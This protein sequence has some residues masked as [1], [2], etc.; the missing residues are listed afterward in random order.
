MRQWVKQRIPNGIINV[1]VP[2]F[3]GTAIFF[4][5]V[6]GVMPIY[7]LGEFARTQNSIRMPKERLNA[8]R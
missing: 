2:E 6:C 4:L 7:A 8:C 3:F 1:A 5:K